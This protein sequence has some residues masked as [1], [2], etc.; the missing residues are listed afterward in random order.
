[1]R[2]RAGLTILEVMIA[3]AVTALA[4][5]ALTGVAVGTLRAVGAS[6]ARTHAGQVLAFLTREVVGGDPRTLAP[7]GTPAAWAYGGLGEAF[8][9]LGTRDGVGDPDRF[10]AEIEHDGAVD[11]VGASAVRYRVAVCYGG[12]EAETCVQA[13]TFGPEP[14]PV[15]DGS[16]LLPGVN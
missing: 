1:V 16:A 12:A 15:G 10:R 11:V 14:G 13:V 4:T 7:E 3:V 8:P 2:R 6:D 5:A 9:E